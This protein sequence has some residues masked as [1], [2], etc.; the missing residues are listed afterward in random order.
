MSGWQRS[1]RK[2]THEHAAGIAE[3]AAG[4]CRILLA[5]PPLSR[6]GDGSRPDPAARPPGGRVG[7][8]RRV[9]GRPYCPA[10]EEARRI[11]WMSFSEGAGGRSTGALTT[12]GPHRFPY[13]TVS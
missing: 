5:A 6:V 10:P 2:S 13:R 9:T 8:N 4:G 11:V 7:C 12:L 1:T 3:A